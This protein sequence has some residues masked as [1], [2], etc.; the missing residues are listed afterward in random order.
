MAITN[1]LLDLIL[2]GT[3]IWMV[4]SVRGVGGIVGRTLNLITAGVIVLGAAHFIA[5]WQHRLLPIDEHRVLHPSRHCLVGLCPAGSRLPPG[6]ELR[7]NIGRWMPVRVHC[8]GHGQD[9]GVATKRLPAQGAI[10]FVHGIRDAAERLRGILMH[11]PAGRGIAPR[12]EALLDDMDRRPTRIV[13][14]R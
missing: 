1:M 7:T 8:G 3:A 6:A 13:P 2:I 14:S 5:T 12:P 9:R 4:T 11:D 10:Q